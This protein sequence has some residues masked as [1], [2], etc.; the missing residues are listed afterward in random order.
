MSNDELLGRTVKLDYNN[1]I[2]IAEYIKNSKTGSNKWIRTFT[3]EKLGPI[4]NMF[5]IVEDG[6]KIEASIKNEKNNKNFFTIK[7]IMLIGLI[8]SIMKII[9]KKINKRFD[10]FFCYNNVYEIN[11]YQKSI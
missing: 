3:G 7:N 2:D 6:E 1:P 11:I 8:V 4:Q 5:V 10:V 9:K